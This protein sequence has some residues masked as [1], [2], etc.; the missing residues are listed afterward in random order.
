MPL[1]KVIDG[2][3]KI[4]ELGNADYNE[5]E[6]PSNITKTTIKG[7]SEVTQLLTAKAGLQVSKTANDVMTVKRSNSGSTR[8][9]IDTTNDSD[10]EIGFYN[11]GVAK[12]LLRYR[13]S[14][15]RTEFT[16]NVGAPIFVFNDD[17][18]SLCAGLLTATGVYST[19]TAE[20]ANVNVSSAGLLRRSTCR[21][22]SKRDI[23]DLDIELSEKTLD[24]IQE[25]FYRSNC[26]TDNRDWSWYGY[27]AEEVAEI[28]PRLVSW[29]YIDSDYEEIENKIIET[30]TVEIDG[31][32]VEKEVE[33][34]E[35][36]KQLKK[37]A[38]LK[39]VGVQY[40]RLTALLNASRKRMKSKLLELEKRIET[41][42]GIY[43][44]K[45]LIVL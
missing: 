16:N 4:L 6:V 45:N 1:N 32:K 3:R 17:G 7:Q 36:I 27:I 12:Q 2:S 22:K 21:L 41:I 29:G 5:I 19:T 24:A 15:N 23:E 44:T 26:N 11:Q 14:Q 9:I 13:T 20:S 43:L 18:S 31:E 38:E 34:I 39:P 28:E 25:I 30:E 40:E 10:S 8:L 35:K 42:E 33:R 37:D